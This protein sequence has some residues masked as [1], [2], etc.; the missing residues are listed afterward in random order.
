MNLENYDREQLL[1]ILNNLLLQQPSLIHQIRAF[2]DAEGYDSL[3]VKS[4][5]ADEH[6]MVNSYKRR[7]FIDYRA[8]QELGSEWYDLIEEH[9]SAIAQDNDWV[10]LC[11]Y[12]A[13]SWQYVYK[14]APNADDDG[15][16]MMLI[17]L[18][19]DTF[20]AHVAS[21][22][23]VTGKS[24]TQLFASAMNA[25]ASDGTRDFL[26]PFW[27]NQAVAFATTPAQ[28]AKIDK[29]I[30]ESRQTGRLSE[31]QLAL[32]TF[33]LKLK[34]NPDLI[35]RAAEYAN[36]ND[37]ILDWYLDYLDQ[38]ND[39]DTRFAVLSM[40]LQKPRN[41]NDYKYRDQLNAMYQLKGP[42]EYYEHMVKEFRRE[43][44]LDGDFRDWLQKHSSFRQSLID[45]LTLPKFGSTAKARLDGLI[46]LS[47]WKEAVTML[48]NAESKEFMRERLSY[49]QELYAYGLTET[50]TLTE[51]FIQGLAN[52]PK[53]GAKR[54]GAV[55]SALVEI[56]LV[57]GQQV[58][59]G[60]KFDTLKSRYPRKRTLLEQIPDAKS[61]LINHGSGK[62]NL[63][64]V[65]SYAFGYNWSWWENQN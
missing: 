17:G 35:K 49:F 16:I 20:N 41:G 48:Q 40:R 33:L 44:S 64:G 63:Y 32:P 2:T 37:A 54:N 57:S 31:Y 47:A 60:A 46:D 59:M 23:T 27:V 29:F 9:V 50:K 51:F 13:K 61:V 38:H 24:Q 18:L 26:S 1:A 43:Q 14:T 6:A 22:M 5:L 53:P 39:V 65:A 12:I 15:D 56:A 8:M 21:M 28:N 3:D 4:M 19:E 30:K 25:A 55:L 34:R 10:A 45:A 36:T 42:N 11:E 62:T 7:G 52:M 58:E